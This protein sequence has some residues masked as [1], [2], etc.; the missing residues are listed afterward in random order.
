MEPRLISFFALVK[1]L[2]QGGAGTPQYIHFTSFFLL[3]LFQELFC[4]S[5]K[6]SLHPI[7]ATTAISHQQGHV[8]MVTSLKDLNIPFWH[9]VCFK[10]AKIIM[11]QSF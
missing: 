11:L 9:D 6:L 2:R 8:H 4:K 1:T 10:I 5:Y 3:H 7:L